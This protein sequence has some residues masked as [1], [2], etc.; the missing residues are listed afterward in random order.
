ML[1]EAYQITFDCLTDVPGCFHAGSALR[2]ASRQSWTRRYKHPVLIWFQINAVL[3]YLVF[4]QSGEAS[5]LGETPGR[6]HRG[7][8][9]F[10]CVLVRSMASSISAGLL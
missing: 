4:Y 10:R 1:P 6:R 2:N 5:T 9:A 7:L 3:H 8:Y